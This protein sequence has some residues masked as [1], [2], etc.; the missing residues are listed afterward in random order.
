MCDVPFLLNSLQYF[1]FLNNRSKC[2]SP[3]FSIITFQ[4]FQGIYFLKYQSSKHHTKLCST[5][6]TSWVPSLNSILI[7]WWEDPFCWRP[8]CAMKIQ[9][10]IRNVSN[11]KE[12]I[13]LW[14]SVLQWHKLNTI[15]ICTSITLYHIH[16][17]IL[18]KPITIQ[19]FFVLWVLYFMV[20]FRRDQ[21]SG[22]PL[23]CKS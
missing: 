10:N 6:S 21:N 18:L 14:R 20:Q 5:C 11:G 12:M 7:C 23:P 17:K 15:L 19:I 8:L 9:W 3:P 2:S 16:I 4:K 1:I 13:C 22:I